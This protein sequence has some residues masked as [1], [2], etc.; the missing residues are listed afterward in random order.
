MQPGCVELAWNEAEPEPGKSQLARWGL[1]VSA[2]PEKARV[3]HPQA[4]SVQSY[5]KGSNVGLVGEKWAVVCT[6]PAEAP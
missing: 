6:S 5:H 4:Q 3:S 1:A 2:M